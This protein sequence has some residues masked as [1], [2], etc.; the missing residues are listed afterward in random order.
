MSPCRAL[1]LA[2]LLAAP[3][4]LAQPAPASTG[5]APPAHTGFQLAVRGG[6]SGPLGKLT[7]EP[8]DSLS[9]SFRI[10]VPLTLDIGG[11]VSDHFFLGGYLGFGF[12]AAGSN[13]DDVCNT[14]L[15]TCGAG[16]LRLGA[17]IQYHFRPAA[18]VNPWAGYG[19]GLEASAVVAQLPQGDASFGASGWDF[20]R[21]MGGVDFRLPTGFGVGPYAELA[22]GRYSNLHEESPGG[23]DQT[24]DIPQKAVHAWLTLGVRIVLFP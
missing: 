19:I 21:L 4:A 2:V 22:V 23:R 7:G 11:K 8:D 14:D 6:V 10:Q 12:G 24:F 9:R 5:G 20:G 1:A 17:L 18:R 15:V 13:F 3:S 16:S